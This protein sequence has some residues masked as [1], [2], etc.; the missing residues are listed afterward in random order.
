MIIRAEGEEE[1]DRRDK[2]GRGT[3]RK[4]GWGADSMASSAEE[5]SWVRKS[6]WLAH[7]HQTPVG[8]LQL[9]QLASSS[10]HSLGHDV[11]EK[12]FQRS[13]VSEGHCQ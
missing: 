11:T 9:H 12:H 2:A 10:S 7:H 1:S 6:L 4:D 8:R 3:S 13:I 5:C